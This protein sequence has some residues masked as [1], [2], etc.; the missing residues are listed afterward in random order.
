MSLRLVPDAE[1]PA[2]YVPDGDPCPTHGL[3][4]WLYRFPGLGLRSQCQGCLDDFL[5]W[6][7]AHTRDVR[8]G[9]NTELRNS[10]I[11]PKPVEKQDHPPPAQLEVFG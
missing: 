1:A 10:V 5:R 7:A 8:P 4:T 2:A 11:R 9:Q 6:F 3:P